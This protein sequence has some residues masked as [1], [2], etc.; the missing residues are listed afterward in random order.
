MEIHHPVQCWANYSELP[1]LLI[2]SMPMTVVLIVSL[3]YF[4]FEV[5]PFIVLHNVLHSINFQAYVHFCF[6]STKCACRA[7]QRKWEL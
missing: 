2:L 6:W 3:I 1:Y 7:W 5:V 4:I